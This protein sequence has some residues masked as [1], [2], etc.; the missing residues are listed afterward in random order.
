MLN[1]QHVFIKNKEIQTKHPKM[2][3]V[4]GSLFDQGLKFCLTF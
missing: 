1:I 3:S 4:L 2:T